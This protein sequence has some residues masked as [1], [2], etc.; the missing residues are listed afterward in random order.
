[1][2][3]KLIY[4][5]SIVVVLSTAGSVTA[6][7]VGWWRLDDGLGT[8]ASDTS[9]NGNDG[10]FNG[11]PH[12]VA[13]HFR[14]ALEFD[15]SGD[16]LDCG[17]GQS[18]RLG[19]AV[20][21]MAWIKINARNIDQKIAGNQNV[22]AGYK[23]AVYSN[24]K[25]EFEIRST[26]N[27]ITSNRNS[28]GRTV[29]TVDEWYHVASVYSLQ[30]G[31]IRTYVN[32]ILDRELA[33]TAELGVSPGP[34]MIGCE[35]DNPGANPFSGTID[36]LR[37][38]STALT[39]D[40]ILTVMEDRKEYPYSLLPDPPDGAFH[41]DTWVPL[42]WKAGDF[43]V[44]HD[45]YLS[46]NFDD[47]NAGAFD[48]FRGN[49]TNTDY[50]AGFPGFAYPDG[51]VPGTT[52]YWRI[53][54]VNDTEPNNPWKG[55]VWSFTVPSRT[56]YFPDPADGTKFL[57]PGKATLSWMAGFGAKLHTFYFGDDFDTVSNAAGG[58]PQAVITYNTD[59]LELDKTYY[60]RVDESDGVTTYKGDVWSFTTMPNIPVTDPTL[61]G[62][63]KLDEGKGMT[64]IDW[65]GHGHHGVLVGDPEW[66]IGH[67]GGALD[68][69]GENYVDT[70]Y[71]EDLATF[72][73]CCWVK[74]SHAPRAASPT[75]PLHR[76]WNYNF[77]WDHPLAIYRG[78]A[79]TYVGGTWYFAS[80]GPLEADTWYHLAATYDGNVLKAYN[81]GVLID[82]NIA[83][84]GAPAHDTHRLTLGGHA[85]YPWFFTG[86]VD[87]ARV[88]NK[89]LTPE[90]IAA[91]AK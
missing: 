62:W 33:T 45:V 32:G 7:L 52:Y 67:D 59:T 79:A 85:V 49:Q 82:S 10:M 30:D 31:Y 66:V 39:E 26:I 41:A 42:S 34:F 37:V 47:V 6:E 81:N 51:L 38:Y 14:G 46:D 80:F 56:A 48:A 4:L 68:F 24:N 11:N 22:N 20:T 89:A 19:D 58:Q 64:A 83:P 2:F 43:A 44:S 90:E 63:W 53:D 54:E 16:W 55:N 87:D 70:D 12:W 13:G 77:E 27:T 35:P 84:S 25:V 15:G 73:V 50:A 88:Y 69:N 9:G 8:V 65:S 71:T 17:T 61:M 21:M 18:L 76:E 3:Q 72:T 78:H 5:L 28:A 40:E 91:L 60:W 74:S 36:D 57:D 1:M 23:M 75:G 29:L 86:T